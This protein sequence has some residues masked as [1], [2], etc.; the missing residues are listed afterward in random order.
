MILGNKECD[1]ETAYLLKYGK[2]PKREN[3]CTQGQPDIRDAIEREWNEP[4]MQYQ[5]WRGCRF[6]SMDWIQ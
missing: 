5:L 1:E 4:D 2:Y 3:R 6:G